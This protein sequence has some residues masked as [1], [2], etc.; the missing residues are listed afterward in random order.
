MKAK[1]TIA[2]FQRILEDLLESTF[3]SRT[4]IRL[5]SASNNLHLDAVAVE[6]LAPG[7]YSLKNDT[8]ITNLRGAATV[9][10][11]E[12]QRRI[13]VQN[14]CLEADPVVPK[15]LIE[16]YG[17]KAQMLGPLVHED[18]LIGLISVHYNPGPREW[19]TEDVDALQDAIRRAQREI[20]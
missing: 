1:N 16:L 14:D 5:D 13:L 3:A 12:E 6:A 7:V 4:T 2:A 15:K 11:L 17:V 20:A 8:L 19:S 18:S 10:F 9:R